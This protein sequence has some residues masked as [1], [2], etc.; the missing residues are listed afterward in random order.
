[1]GVMPARLVGLIVLGLLAC[2]AGNV[3]RGERYDEEVATYVGDFLPAHPPLLSPLK[4]DPNEFRNHF[5]LINSDQRDPLQLITAIAFR[6]PLWE[7]RVS[8]DFTTQ[9]VASALAKQRFNLT[10]RTVLEAEDYRYALS[11]HWGYG[12][13]TGTIEDAHHSA[14]SGDQYIAETLF[15]NPK[16]V[17]DELGTTLSYDWSG[18]LRLVGGVYGAYHSSEQLE[19]KPFRGLAGFEYYWFERC[20]PG[21]IGP[22]LGVNV[23]ALQEDD[24]N[25]TSSL[26][27]GWAFPGIAVGRTLDFQLTAV[28]GSTTTRTFYPQDETYFGFGLAADL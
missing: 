26:V 6:L 7:Y 24:W 11:L 12:P 18:K 1:M 3:L 9:F 28:T 10:H 5:T 13:W 21:G 22:Y 8:A 14:H 4:A 16:Y 25:T 20:T 15:V 2:A 17:R 23:Q 19:G 27:L